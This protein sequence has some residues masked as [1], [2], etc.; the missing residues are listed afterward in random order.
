MTLVV[1]APPSPPPVRPLV[2]EEQPAKL[3]RANVKSPKSV[4][5]PSL[6]IVTYWIIFT[7]LLPPA[8]TPLVDE[9]SAASEDLA[10]VRLPKSVAFPRV[11]ITTKSIVLTAPLAKSVPPPKTPL[12]RSGGLGQSETYCICVVSDHTPL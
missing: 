1:G 9:A 8:Q 3:C 6:S 2:A 10:A 11:E 5:L 7:P 4:A 12:L